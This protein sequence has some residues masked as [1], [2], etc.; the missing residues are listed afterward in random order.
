MGNYAIPS[1]DRFPLGCMIFLVA[2]LFLL[3]AVVAA[4]GEVPR[5]VVLREHVDV[6]EANTYYS[7][8]DEGDKY[9]LIYKPQGTQFLFRAWDYDSGEHQIVAWRMVKG[10]AAET[11][12]PDVL[13]IDL[14]D[15]EMLP[16][17]LECLLERK[18]RQRT[19]MAV[20]WN[21]G[22]SVWQME[23]TDSGIHRLI[24]AN[25]FQ[26]THTIGDPELG[27]RERWPKELRRE[28]RTNKD[29]LGRKP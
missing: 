9:P 16:K 6:I 12:E 10:F 8:T 2:A 11:I 25:S 13:L 19:H 3:V 1:R 7:K 17:E 4:Q 5:S 23:W 24:T 18:P 22:K 14:R 21:H 29:L 20:E 15:A 27:E 26:E 28:L